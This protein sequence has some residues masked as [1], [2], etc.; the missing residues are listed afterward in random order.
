MVEYNKK[1][2]VGRVYRLIKAMNLPKM[3]KVKPN[4]RHSK[5]N[6]SSLKNRLNKEFNPKAPN[7]VWVSDITYVKVSGRFCYVCA[8]MDLFSR[9]I[10]AHKVST[11]IDSKLVL[12]TF[13]LA[14]S[15]R[16]HSKGVMFNSDQG[17]Q[18][19]AIDFRKALDNSEFVHSLLAKSLSNAALNPFVVY[20]T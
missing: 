13:Y 2:S 12:D 20:I 3:F 15:K 11:N 10:I 19:T 17:T 9:K 8:I 18:Y 7:Q 5:T 1:V 14:C 4:S 6:E 16:N